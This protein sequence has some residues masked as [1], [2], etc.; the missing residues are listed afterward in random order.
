MK[1][2][3]WGLVMATGKAEQISSEIET[4]FLYLNDRTVLA[5]SLSAFMHCADIDGIVVVV[6]RER[7]ESVLGMVQMFGFSKVKKIVVGGARRA[8]SMAAGLEHVDEDVEWVCVHDASRPMIKPDLVA[9]TVKCA[10]RHGSGVAAMEIPDAVVSAKKG[11]LE[12][13]LDRDG[14]LWAAISPQTWPRAALAKAY[15]KAAKNRKNY[16][17]DLEAMLAAKVEPRLVPTAAFS[18]RIRSADD[19]APVLALM[20]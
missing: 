18:L 12:S 17:D 9:E 15:P 13:R 16:E 10:K 11:V 14:R 4:A 19:L 6:S 5:H 8:A 20:K 3:A 7:A 2:A 1:Q